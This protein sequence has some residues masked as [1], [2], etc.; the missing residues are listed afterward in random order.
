MINEIRAAKETKSRNNF[1]PSL[2]W[3]LVAK[4]VQRETIREFRQP[5]LR[6]P[7]SFGTA[8]VPASACD[9]TVTC[10]RIKE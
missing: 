8:E 5:T 10:A 4:S 3:V 1:M 7:S 6:S 2:A 9:H